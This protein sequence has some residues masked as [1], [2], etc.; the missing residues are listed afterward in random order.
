M[1]LNSIIEQD[2]IEYELLHPTERTP[3][4]VK[5]TLAGAEHP[6]RKDLVL[7]Y[8]RDLRR[9]TNKAGKL[10]LEDPAE[11]RARESEFLVASTLGWSGLEID[12]KAISY[13]PEAARAFYDD[14]RFAWAR[15]QIN[16]ALG[17]QELFIKSSSS[18]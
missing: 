12:G 7:Q 13:S 8:T 4:G 3:L 10:S 11:D 2:Q 5:F 16:G 17:E 18:N 6:K 15:R 9:R 1:Y 14:K